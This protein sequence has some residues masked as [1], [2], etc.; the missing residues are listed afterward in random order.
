[1]ET[2]ALAA[3]NERSSAKDPWRNDG[4]QTS[5]DSHGQ[6]L[7]LYPIFNIIIQ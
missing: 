6:A 7:D 1:M 5:E 4:F 3:L 2:A